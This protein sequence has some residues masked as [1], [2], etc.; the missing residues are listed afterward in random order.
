MDVRVC[1]MLLHEVV[2]YFGLD[3]AQRNEVCS[4]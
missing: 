3:G 1:Q 2:H 4:E